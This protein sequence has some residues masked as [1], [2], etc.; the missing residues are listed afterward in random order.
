MWL[1]PRRRTHS[2]LGLAL[3]ME[4][5]FGGWSKTQFAQGVSSRQ[6][7]TL[8]NGSWGIREGNGE[9]RSPASAYVVSRR[10]DGNCASTMSVRSADSVQPEQGEAAV[11]LPVSSS[12]AAVVGKQPELVIRSNRRV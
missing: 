7:A 2:A 5:R 1:C 4:R 10:V 9:E 8:G 6:A 3:G 11:P 12:Y